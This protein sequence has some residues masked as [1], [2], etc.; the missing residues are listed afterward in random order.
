MQGRYKV[1]SPDLKPLFERAQKM[2]RQLQY[3]VA[4]HVRRELNT[5]ADALANLALDGSNIFSEGMASKTGSSISSADAAE[6]QPSISASPSALSSRVPA[7]KIR[8]RYADGV[9][10]PAEP[11]DLPEGSEVELTLRIPPKDH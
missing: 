1:K 8:A 9:L 10:V 6:G 2:T 11:L 7:K 3:F 4:E 5:E